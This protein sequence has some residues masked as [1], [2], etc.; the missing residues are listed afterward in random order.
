MSSCSHRWS[1]INIRSGH[2]VMEGCH[3]C[4]ARGTYFSSEPVAPIEEYRDDDHYWQHLGS[5]QAVMFDLR[6]DTCGQ[7]VDLS[8]MAGLMLS[9]CDEKDCEVGALALELGRDTSIYVALCSDSTHP[10]GGCVSDEGIAALDEHF[11][12]RLRPGRKKIRVVPCMMCSN[13]DCCRGIVIADS[14]LT[15]LWDDR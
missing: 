13:V 8:D 5:S 1:M 7:T 15:D 10:S 12:Q 11:N 6:C 9:T 14:G 2:L 3:H 4:G